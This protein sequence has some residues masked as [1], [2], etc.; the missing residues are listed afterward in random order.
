MTSNKKQDSLLRQGSD[1]NLY[2]EDNPGLAVVFESLLTEIIHLTSAQFGIFSFRLEDG[3]LKSIYGNPPSN[4]IEEAKLVSEFCFKTGQDFNLKKGDSPNKLIPALE[5]NSVCCVLH[6]GELGDSSSEDQ[7]KIF[8]TIFLGRSD[9]EGGEFRE[10]DFVHLKATVRIISD[11]LEESFIS[12][13]SSLVVLSL[14]TISRVALES[15]QIRKQ[16]DR[17]DFLL[18]EIIRVSGLINKSLDLS[19]LLEAI[20]LSSKS[21]FRTEACSV[22]LLDDTK[23]YLY[24]HT[25]LGEKRDEVTKVRVPVGKGVAG[26]VVQDKKP[27]IINDA[28]NDPRVYREVDKASH[29]VTRNIM[30]A[31]LLVEGQVIGVIEAINTIDRTFFTE[32]DL[33]LFLSF[34][35]TSALAIQKTGLLQN[36]EDANKDLRKKVSELESLFELS[37]VVSSAKSQADLMKQSVPVIHREMDAGKTGI[38]LINRRMGV[39]TS[40]SYT[41]EKTVE[42]L[43]T[44]DYQ[45][46]FIHRSI[47]EEKT[48]VKEDIQNFAFTHGLDLEYLKGSYIVLPLTHQGKKPFGAITVSDRVDK[49]SYNHSQL[50]LLRTFASLIARGHETL[51]L[52]NEMISRKAMQRSLE[53]EIEITREIQKNILPESKK[54]HSNFDLGVKSVPAKEVSGDFYDYYQYQ[55][56]QYS[57]L[58][59]DVSGKSLPA[60]IFMAMS[61]SI[62]RTLARNHDLDPEDILKQGNALIY[63]DSH[64]GMFVT[65]FFIH[66]NPAIF[67][68]DYASAGHND[69]VLIRKDGSW[70]LIKGSGPPL[71]VV[72]S[73]SYKGGSLIVE[74]EDMVILYTDGAIEEKNAKDE[75]FGLER[76]I[77]EVIVRK[78][79]PSER[80]IEELFGLVREFSG[81][82]ELFDDFTVMILKFNDNYQFSRVFD[83]STASIPLFREF[84]YET[85][86]VRNLEDSQRDD[87]LLACDEAGTNIVMHGYENTDLKNPKFECKIRFTGDW[88][89]I[90]L[91]DSGKVFQRKNVQEPSIEDNLSGKRKGGFGVYL[92]EKLM[93]S[94]DYSSEGGKNVLV[95][96]K[97]FQNKASNGNNV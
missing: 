70:E 43:R 13:E 55:D 77:R 83:A 47:E 67:T 44:A 18:T 51:K 31:P 30:A 68:L 41:L 52:Q 39:L 17:F 69:Q 54:F 75:E 91:I 88:I 96:K 27:M 19:Q 78:H 40:I 15:V 86:K 59:S 24:F 62:I 36:L 92:I 34:S 65:T 76:M 60:A 38:F 29:F 14:M 64:N 37:Q 94:V 89:T 22:L 10:S 63:E 46:S 42:I 21:V 71:G 6:V 84:V 28:M 53:R 58:V 81:A 56:G 33:E 32:A 9:G 73:A 79:L 87:I 11:L 45:G 12:G 8:G 35:G 20:M 74:P 93:D 3:T 1:G 4:A 72:P 90:V 2:L 95:L 7:K 97:N 16:T 57:F 66:Y 23:E 25:V 26:M 5:Q 85:I 49:L 61:S 80:I 50:R 48:T 82:P